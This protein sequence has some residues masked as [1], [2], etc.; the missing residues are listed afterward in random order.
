MIQKIMVLY[1]RYHIIRV[2]YILVSTVACKH[3][4]RYINED[5]MNKNGSHERKQIKYLQYED[6]DQ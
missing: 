4:E 6:L 5:P 3:Q 1:T 2:N